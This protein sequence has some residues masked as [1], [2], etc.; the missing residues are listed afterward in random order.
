MN[1]ILY[2]ISVRF[3]L[4]FLALFGVSGAAMAA[5][6]SNTE[7]TERTTDKPRPVNVQLTT[8]KEGLPDVV[9]VLLDDVGFGAASTFG[10]PVETPALDRLADRGLRYNRFHTTA[11]CSPTRA[12]LMTGRNSHAVGW[13]R[14]S[15]TPSDYPGYI[16]K[17]PDSAATLPEILRRNGYATSLWGKWHLTPQYEMSPVGP[18]D[19][20]PTSMGFEKFYGML[21]GETDHFAPNLYDGTTLVKRPNKP[22]Y[23]LTEDLADEAIAWMH[24]QNSITPDKPFFVHFSTGA[25]HAPLHAPKEWIERYQGRFDTGWDQLRE[26]TFAKQKTL[27][28]IPESTLLTPRPE[29]LPAWEEMTAERKKIAARLMETYAGMLAHTDMQ[30]GRLM[31]SLEAMGRLDNTLFIYIVG[32]NGGSGEGSP[33]GTLNEHGRL[34]GV[35]E[36]DAQGIERL[37]EIGGKTTF[38]Q[39]PAGFAWAVNTPFQWTKQVAGHFGGT[40]NPMVISWPDKITDKGGLRS[41]FSHVNSIMPTVLEAT[42]IEAPKAVNG[43]TQMPIDGISLLY[44]FDAEK[45]A[46]RHQTQ[47]FEIMGNRGIYHEG[48]IASAFRGRL[49]WDVRS[50]ITQAFDEDT[51]ELY[52]VDQ[53]FSQ[54]Q[55]LAA[56]EPDRLRKLQELFWV[57]AERNQVLPLQSTA[58]STASPYP[59]DRTSFT[60]YPGAVGIPSALAPPMMNR[61]HS[62]EAQVVVGS[63]GTE[64]VLL[65]QGGQSAG[66]SLFVDANGYLNYTYN[67]FG[68]TR[69]TFVSERPIKAGDR[70]LRVEVTPEESGYG[71]AAK[72]HLF[73]DGE[74]VVEGRLE[75][76]VPVYYSIDETL[77]VGTDKGSP[78]G[79]Y[80]VDYDFTGELKNVTIRLH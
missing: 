73:V 23:H 5:A 70:V 65:A 50:P 3:F 33:E 20:W 60:Y 22:D 62:I 39:Y 4:S 30:V 75:R 7:Q 58:R 76:T 67:F 27:G 74:K 55:D 69:T 79:D 32:D 68:V 66:Y 28:V 42:G 17:I 48:W 24:L 37:D 38:P 47:Y 36:T 16:N 56:S 12:A 29:G 34:Q 26:E 57:E 40:R 2:L 14:P 63:E 6:G 35:M 21:G 41:Q 71:K 77:D 11:I 52:N 1:K 64:G 72:V 59:A 15:E 53:D 45:A 49:P 44:T 80:P 51:W 54:A 13:A 31:D 78:V 8:A 9:L 46:E 10:G 19:R 43:V 18:F 61:A 25:N